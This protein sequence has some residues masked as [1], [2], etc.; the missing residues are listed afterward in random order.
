M[1]GPQVELALLLTH[2]VPTSTTYI[3][4]IIYQRLKGYH[5]LAFWRINININDAK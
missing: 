2:L 4:I 3:S 5:I 1:P